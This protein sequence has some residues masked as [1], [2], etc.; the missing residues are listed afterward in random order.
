MTYSVVNSYGLAVLGGDHLHTRRQAEAIRAEY[1]D[2]DLVVVADDEPELDDTAPH[3]KRVN[4]FAIHPRNPFSILP[5][6]VEDE[7]EAVRELNAEREAE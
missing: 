7:D 4:I 5:T 3:T 2:T 1:L 6:N